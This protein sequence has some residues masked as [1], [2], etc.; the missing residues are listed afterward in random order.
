MNISDNYLSHYGILGM[1]W[2]VRNGPPYPLSGGQ[3]TSLEMH[4]K[5]GGKRKSKLRSQDTVLKEGTKLQTLSADK[6]RLNGADMYYA[7]WTPKDKQK[8]MH[9]FNRLM[10]QPVYDS[11]GNMVGTKKLRKYNLET[12]AATDVKIASENASADAFKKLYTTNRDFYNYVTD[13]SRMQSLFVD[14][15]YKFR[16]YRQARKV[17]EKCRKGYVPNGSDLQVIYRM[18][19]YTLPNL[20]KDT[21]KQRGKFFKELSKA[22]YSGVLD[23]NDALYG[24][25]QAQNP[26]IVFDMSKMVKNDAYRTTTKDLIKTDIN[27]IF[28]SIL[29]KKDD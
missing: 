3:Y 19:N 17:L 20:D 7:A 1:K 22:G 18:Y 10:E 5:G 15:K 27:A 14:D 4:Y 2:G 6:D 26:V 11:D 24:G 9:L 23:T 21:I 12:V 8:Y 16:G 25:Y 29:K 28:E 13:P